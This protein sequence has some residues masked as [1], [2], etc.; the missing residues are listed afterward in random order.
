MIFIH[1]VAIVAVFTMIHTTVAA[2]LSATLRITTITH[3][4]VAIVTGLDAL[5]HD[6]VTT[7]RT[8]TGIGAGIT[9][10]LIAIVTGL[11]T[12]PATVTTTLLQTLSRTPIF[13]E[14][15]AIITLFKAGLTGDRIAA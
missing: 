9:I 4:L 8:L 6:S 3:A 2:H 1:A 15:V 13:I 11:S 10:V 7:Y 14:Q 5:V 12:V